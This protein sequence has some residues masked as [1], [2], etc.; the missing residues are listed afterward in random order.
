MVWQPESPFVLLKELWESQAQ[1]SVA[2]GAS[3]VFVQG[4]KTFIRIKLPFLLMEKLETL[5]LQISPPKRVWLFPQ[6]K[7]H[8]ECAKP[9]YSHL[10]NS[11]C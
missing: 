8:L 4:G 5:Y 11:A 1:C 3:F 10:Q 6:A 9:T 7:L 2:F